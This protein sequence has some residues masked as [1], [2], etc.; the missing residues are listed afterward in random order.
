MGRQINCAIKSCQ[1]HLPTTT[2]VPQLSRRPH[3]I[4]A[5]S[6]HRA[7]YWLS[8]AY[9]VERRSA[10][11]KHGLAVGR[12]DPRDMTVVNCSLDY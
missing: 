6:A 10:H 7:D 4:Q 3:S 1:A 2:T 11:E 5:N 8:V 12:H 9:Q